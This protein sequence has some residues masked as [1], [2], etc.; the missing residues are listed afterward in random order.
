MRRLERTHIL[1]RNDWP[2]VEAY[3]AQARKIRG[4]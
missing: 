4:R 3:L 1:L 2:T